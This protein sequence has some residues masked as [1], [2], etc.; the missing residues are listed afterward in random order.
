MTSTVTKNPLTG[1]I[2]FEYC[3]FLVGAVQSWVSCFL[4]F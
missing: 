4:H 2:E 3:S 1:E